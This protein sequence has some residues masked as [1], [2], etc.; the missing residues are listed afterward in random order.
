MR[1][2]QL[3]DANGRKH[4]AAIE[5]ADSAPRLVIGV[6]STR[7]LALLAYR[8]G[9]SIATAIARLGLGEDVDYEDAIKQTP[10]SITVR[11]PRAIA[12]HCRSNGAES[13]GQRAVA[14]RDAREA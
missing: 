10:H 3:L 14:R 2:I 6:D 4:V 8:A 1:L 7:E 5:T 13:L 9:E 11:S 12:L